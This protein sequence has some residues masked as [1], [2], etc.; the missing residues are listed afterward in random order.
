MKL[1]QFWECPRCGTQ[2]AMGQPGKLHPP[3]C[4][5]FHPR[6]EMEQKTEAAWQGP[7]ETG[8]EAG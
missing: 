1:D 8:N 6:V 5:L 4:N 3:S 2:T 7:P